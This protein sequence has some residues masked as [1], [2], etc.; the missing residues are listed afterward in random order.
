MLKKDLDIL[1][2]CLGEKPLSEIGFGGCQD[3]LVVRIMEL[4]KVPGKMSPERHPRTEHPQ[5]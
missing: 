1:D 4:D 3:I 5:I 2:L